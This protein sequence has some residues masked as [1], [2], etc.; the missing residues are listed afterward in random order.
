MP[1]YQGMTI[2]GR[3]L[4]MLTT[5]VSAQ[6]LTHFTS[7]S[8]L[9]YKFLKVLSRLFFSFVFFSPP[10]PHSTMWRTLECLYPLGKVI[11]SSHLADSS[12][13]GPLRT[14]KH[15]APVSNWEIS[16]PKATIWPKALPQYVHPKAQTL[17]RRT[18]A[19]EIVAHYGSYCAWQINKPSFL[20]LQNPALL[21][22]KIGMESRGQIFGTR[23]T[24]SLKFPG[25]IY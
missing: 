25:G 2:M 12:S 15:T 11:C 18:E 5:V 8:T 17:G 16:R 9:N 24:L 14:A 13:E 22:C 3:H 19:S 4:N 1:F 7:Q 20:F 23:T 10:T 21:I 6:L